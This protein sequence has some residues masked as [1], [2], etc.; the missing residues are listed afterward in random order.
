M[1]QLKLND[2]VV[3]GTP[4]D[5]R[6]NIRCTKHIDYKNFTLLYNSTHGHKFLIYFHN[7][8]KFYSIN[9]KDFNEIISKFKIKL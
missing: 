2:L 1:V 7:T 9:K 4:I 6:D 8:L 5:T 3:N